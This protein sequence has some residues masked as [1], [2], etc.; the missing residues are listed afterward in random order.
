M[1]KASLRGFLA[2]KGRMVL[3]AVAITLSVAFVTGTLMFVDTVS[4]VFAD[5][6]RSTSADVT[7]TPRTEVKAIRLV[8]AGRTP[9]VPAALVERA[10]GVEGVAAVHGDVVVRDVPVVDGEGDRVGV[11]SDPETAVAGWCA[12][13]H[14]PVRLTSGHEPRG[15][16]EAVLDAESARVSRIRLGD[17]LRLSPS[18]GT[19]EVTVVGIAGYR[20]RATG[21]TL[22]FVDPATA[23]ARLLGRP[24]VVTAVSVTAAPGV[25]DTVLRDRVAAALDAEGAGSP[26]LDIRTRAQT[27]AAAVGE[28]G[29]ALDVVRYGLLGFALMTM[30]IGMFLIFNTFSM[31]VAQRTREIGLLRALGASRADVRRSVL[32]EAAVLGLLG[33]TLGLGT[34]YALATGLTALLGAV[35]VQSSGIDLV[36]APTTPVVGYAVGTLATVLAAYRPARRASRVAPMAALRA[37]DAPQGPPRRRAAL[38]GGV[39]LALGAAAVAAGNLALLALGGVLTLFGV[40]LLGPILARRLIPTLC[41]PYIRPFGAV[42][43]LGRDNALRNPRRTGATAGALMI[44]VALVAAVG[45]AVSSMTASFDATFDRTFRADLVLSGKPALSARTATDARAVPGVAST[46]RTRRVDARI[47]AHEHTDRLELDGADPGVGALLGHTYGRGTEAAG[48]APGAIV[49][50]AR[51]ARRRGLA[52]GDPVVVRAVAGETRTLRVGGLRTDRPAGTGGDVNPMV[53]LD[54]LAELAPDVR[55]ETV[56]LAATPGTDTT[57]LRAAVRA[58]TSAEPGVAVRTRADYRESR[59]AALGTMVALAYGL[60]SLT[61]VIAVLGVVNTLVLSV[62]ERTREIAMLRAL[63][64]TRRQV[65]R[66]IR[67]ESV[68]IALYGA[69]LGLALGLGW[70]LG[71]T[72]W[73]AH[74]GSVTVVAVPWPTIAAVIAGATLAG[75]AAATLPARRAARLDI[76]AAIAD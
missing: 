70:G 23:A 75:L 34:G 61:I 18:T 33:S 26:A 5:L 44:G 37:V 1:L 20:V 25:P 64:L 48:L 16:N 21:D 66:M 7:V 69:T 24:D 22:V 50:D 53:G 60:L 31:L 63:G 65:R 68:T 2:H 15:P 35:G 39:V 46:V 3:S 45:V 9:T 72:R 56:Y 54:T 4:A 71:V 41:A 29:G 13:A 10:R 11:V 17:R 57:V 40:V 67:L 62:V 74:D 51:Y 27:G 73:M 49:L 42:G 55:D 12:C 30:A 47:T 32:T 28:L 36:F 52:V 8:R 43:R 38:R 59:K 58:A 6:A 14:A 19:F 76:P